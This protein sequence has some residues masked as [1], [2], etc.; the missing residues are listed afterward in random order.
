MK[1]FAVAKIVQLR[2]FNFEYAIRP[3]YYFSRL[4]GLWPFSIIHDSNGKIRRARID[5]FDILCPILVICLN[6]LFSLDAYKSS[7][8]GLKKHAIRIRIIVFTVF[9]I[10]SLLFTAIGIA[11]DVINRNRLVDI[12]AKFDTFDNE[13]RYFCSKILLVFS[14]I[15]MEF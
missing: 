13:V 4:A 15:Q 11:L 6:V 3:V 1:T 14:Q 12:L 8:L 2:K 10:S 7:K 5:V 9:Q